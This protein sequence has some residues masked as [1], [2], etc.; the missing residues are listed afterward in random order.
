MALNDIPS[1]AEIS[2]IRSR[3]APNSEDGEIIHRL[4]SAIVALKEELEVDNRRTIPTPAPDDDLLLNHMV[5]G[6]APPPGLLSMKHPEHQ[7]TAC[8]DQFVPPVLPGTCPSCGSQEV[9][10]LV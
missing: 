8:L 5:L 1:D 7:C 9:N 6:V 2:S 3:W 4:C 10:P